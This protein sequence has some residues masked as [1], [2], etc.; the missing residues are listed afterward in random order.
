MEVHV[1]NPTDVSVSSVFCFLVFF[2]CGEKGSESVKDVKTP[3]NIKNM[4]WFQVQPQASIF[5]LHPVTSLPAPLHGVRQQ[6]LLCLL[7][8]YSSTKYSYVFLQSSSQYGSRAFNRI[9]AV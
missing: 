2:F 8:V 5:K 7:K 6:C 9:E 1:T 3:Q 4:N